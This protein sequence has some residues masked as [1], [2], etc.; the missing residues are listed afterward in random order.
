MASKSERLTQGDLLGS[1]RAVARRTKERKAMAQQKS[2]RRV[3][4]QATR[5]RGVTRG[6][7]SRGGAK[8]TPVSKQMQQLGLRFGTAEESVKAEADG[9]AAGHLSRAATRAEPKP[10]RR[11]QTVA[12]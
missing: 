1:A 12:S 9:E 3:R 4:A 10:R 6:V 2:E 5:K 7:E 8:A 11:E